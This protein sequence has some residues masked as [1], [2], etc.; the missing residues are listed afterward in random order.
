MFG[1]T[2]SREGTRSGGA[3][4]A[5]IG[6]PSVSNTSS[7][8][9]L[10]RR[11]RRDG[12]IE[13]LL[14]PIGILLTVVVFSL[15]SDH[16]L[17]SQNLLN[18]GTSACTLGIVAIGETLVIVAGGFD[19]SVGAQVAVCGTAAAL[20]MRGTGSVVVG[21]VVGLTAGLAYG[22]INGILV[23]IVSVNSFIATLGTLVVGE[24]VALAISGAQP[25]SGL[26][27]SLDGFS[28][29]HPL[30]WSWSA[31]LLLGC[32]A[33]GTIVLH[34]TPFGIQ[35]Q[36]I[37]G[38]LRAARLAGL[39]TRWVI[40]VVFALTGV[41]AGIAALAQTANLSAGQPTADALLP[42]YGIAAAVLGGSSLAGG[43]GS[44]LGTLFGV[45]LIG[46]IENGLT[47]VGVAAAYQD[48]VVGL[49]FLVAAS[50]DYVR[51][52]VMRT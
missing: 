43:R 14:L 32:F 52:R 9:G 36:A 12:R 8:A 21:I 31:W 47:I 3:P 7:R 27:S 4:E 50:S 20:V 10:R 25:I 13:I 42:L 26:P 30:G 18:I 11:L 5:G 46:V 17:T 2:S 24:G 35:V 39:R 40:F 48:V 41:L 51:S 29:G 15:L 38:N 6:A 1:M 49:V 37:G 34:V 44:M 45:L 19:L 16:F 22:A 33:V 23:A 28:L